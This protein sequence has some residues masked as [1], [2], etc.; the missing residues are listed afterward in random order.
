MAPTDIAEEEWR[1]DPEDWPEAV[2]ACNGP[3]VVVGG[4][5]TGKTEFLV[6]R[7]LH[8]IEHRDLPSSELLV[9]SFGRRGTADLETR[10]RTGLTGSVPQIDVATFHALA[11]RIVEAESVA[12][13]WKRPPQILTGPEQVDLIQ[14]ML[15]RSERSLW[16]PAF[17]GLLGG[18]TFAREVTDF[19]L[20][21]REHLISDRALAARAEERDDWRGLAEFIASYD[22]ELRRRGRIDYGTLLAE[23]VRALEDPAMRGAMADRATYVLVD[24]YQD[25]TAAQ[26]RLLELL[27]VRNRNLTVAADPYQSIYS[28]RGADLRNVER[29]PDRFRGVAGEPATRLVLTTSFRT[30]AR[31]L[32]AAVRV[33]SGTLP[34]AAGPVVPSATG[35]RVDVYKFDQQTAEAE[36]IA[37]EIQRLNLEDGI[38]FSELAVFVRSKQR[39]VPDLIRALA[40]RGLPHHTPDDRLADRAAARFVLDLVA[41]ATGSD[42]P[43]GTARAVRRILLGSLYRVPLGTLREIERVRVVT[44]DGSWAAALR[45]V[46]PDGG[47]LADLFD[48]DSWATDKPAAV[49]L[50]EVWSHLTAV[51]AVVLDP[52]RIEEREA[53]SSLS[54]VLRRWNERNPKATLADYRRLTEEEDFEARPLLSYRTP[55]VGRL[56]ITTLHQ[57]K[58]LEF[59]V[60]FIADA[61]E[62]VFPDLRSRD[63]LL[64]VRHL[65]PHLP[66]GAA[67]YR[68]FRLQEERRLAYTGMSRARR[69]VVWT[70]TSTGFEEGRGIPSR[71][72]A[73][74]AGTDTVAEATTQVPVPG[75]PV[76]PREAEGLLRRLVVDPGEG[77]PTRLA[78][79]TV[80]AERRDP[81]L[82][83]PLSFAGMRARGTDTGVIPDDLTLSPSQAE[84][85]DACPRRYVLE[86]RLRIGAATSV[87]ADFGSLLHRVL[88]VTERA[89]MKAGRAH[90]GFDEAASVLSD[91]FDRSV[92]GGPPFSDA[93]L[94]RGLDALEHLYA[95]WPSSGKAVALEKSLELEV[96]GVR[97]Q[98]RVDR[99]EAAGEG[100]AI[101]DYKTSATAAR[102]ADVEESIQLGF[103]VLAA[104]ADESL[105]M[106]GPPRRAEMWYPAAGGKSVKTRSLDMDKLAAVHERLTDATRGIVAEDW[107]PRPGVQCDRCQLR[108]VCPAW[109]QGREAFA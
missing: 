108:S 105:E 7:A 97:W 15:S 25:T 75:D 33:T 10:L 66:D 64:G 13:G 60:V 24:E 41:A 63:S 14:D 78:A 29:F 67:D 68:A 80:L 40:R 9:L 106:H 87:Y 58:G 12:L 5:G 55:A 62:G 89:A 79:L 21:T 90:G 16:S 43:A 73:L 34:G 38:P 98:G 50:W 92:F 49:G 104:G 57:S 85:Y 83:D 53:W 100:I 54:Q 48:D 82:R 94:Q 84:S 101:V 3:Q 76:T 47:E 23:A 30:P 99:I 18:A 20:R 35:G 8:L 93:W 44:Y 70:A 6:R 65:L 26:A 88:D 4:P 31:I 39:F 102:I 77:A 95:N 71:F 59:D 74:V 56:T 109:R 22:A 2:A 19:V 52:Q 11:A 107:T 91:E 42:G 86:K 36:W 28:F 45:A 61:V 51:A 17:R 81:R 32:E 37:D 46:V 69:R 103:Y 27:T 96:G 1:V 72:L